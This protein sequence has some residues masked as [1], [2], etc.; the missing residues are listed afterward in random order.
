MGRAPFDEAERRL[1]RASTASACFVSNVYHGGDFVHRTMR[2]F[3]RSRYTVRWTRRAPQVD[4]P[5]VHRVDHIVLPVV[6]AM[7]PFPE[8]CAVRWLFRA[9]IVETP[10][11]LR[12]FHTRALMF[13]AMRWFPIGESLTGLLSTT[14]VGAAF[15]AH[16]FHVWFLVRRTMR[17]LLRLHHTVCGTYHAPLMG[18]HLMYHVYHIGASVHRTMRRFLRP[19]YTVRRTRHACGVRTSSLYPNARH[20]GRSSLRRTNKK[21]Y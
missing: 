15:A 9:P 18:A 13:R 6:D 19:R 3:L 12:V 5:L 1:L 10:I 8:D 20:C 4:A 7:S 21:K 17:R 2:R 16:V 11:V 14:R